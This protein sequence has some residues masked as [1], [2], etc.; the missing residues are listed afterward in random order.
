MS[1]FMNPALAGSAFGC[2]VSGSLVYYSGEINFFVLAIL[3]YFS[4]WLMA[5]K[6]LRFFDFIY[7]FIYLAQVREL[8]MFLRWDDMENSHPLSILDKETIKSI[9]LF[10]KAIIRR[11]CVEGTMAKYLLDFGK[12]RSVPDVVIKHGM[13][14]E[15][16]TGEK[17]KYW[18]DE[19][20][21]P[22]HLLKS[23][24]ERRITRKAT[25]TNSRK[26]RKS[27]RSMKK[28]F[29]EK[30]FDYLFSRAERADSHQCGHCN[31]HVPIRYKSFV[32]L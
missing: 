32:L 19:S 2:S 28:P 14:V 9:R 6:F 21:V 30:G 12:R 22:L 4:L 29:K 15:D 23:F 18:L 24:E 25:K 8:D 1:I 3:L 10:K 17:K 16:S 26:A 7:L 11:K 5:T 20:Y 31:K 13:K 27:G